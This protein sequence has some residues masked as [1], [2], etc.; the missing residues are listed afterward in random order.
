MDEVKN[1]PMHLPNYDYKISDENAICLNKFKV[2]VKKESRLYIEDLCISGKNIAVTSV[3]GGGKSTFTNALGQIV[4]GDSW[5]E[6][7]VTYLTKNGT[8]PYIAM[9]SQATYVTPEDAL[10]E[11]ITF[12]K[13][14]KASKQKDEVIK[15]LNEI[16]I[17]IVQGTQ[18][19]L[20]SRLN[21][22]DD[23]VNIL[24]GGQKQKI[25]VIRLILNHKQAD[26]LFLDE[27]FAGLDHDSIIT[28]QNMFDKYFPNT[29]IMVI[30]HEAQ[31]HNISGWYD[32]RLH[33]ANNTAMLVGEFSQ[34]N[35]I[36]SPE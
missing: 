13:G 7:S 19:S 27:I 26:F 4:H 25:D 1:P 6:G 3:S 34:I 24:S 11:L 31:S 17:D 23:W 8:K 9:T 18:Q 5:S 14:F 29:M 35:E 36:D 12:K 16:K 32:D 20:I 2:G 15:L 30:D 21:V 33:F 28:I 22:I 10:L